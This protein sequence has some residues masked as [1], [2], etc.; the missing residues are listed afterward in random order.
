MGGNGGKTWFLKEK[1]DFRKN[2][3]QGF[4][5]S[6]I[7]KHH[8]WLKIEP[9]PVIFK[10]CLCSMSSDLSWV[11]S[12]LPVNFWN[13]NQFQSQLQLGVILFN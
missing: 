6:R 2:P 10:L 11:D 5:N 8:W 3:E 9:Y 1:L 7:S 4:H 13:I 12:C